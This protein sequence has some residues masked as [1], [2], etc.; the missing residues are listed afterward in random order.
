M[1]TF[2]KCSEFWFSVV[3]AL[4]GILATLGVLTPDKASDITKN[5]MTII[6]Y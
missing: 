3:P 6:S 4:L 5:A 1:K 2:W